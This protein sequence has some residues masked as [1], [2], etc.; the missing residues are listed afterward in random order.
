MEERI[1]ARGLFE[2]SRDRLNDLRYEYRALTQETSKMIKINDV[3]KT[4]LLLN[5]LGEPEKTIGNIK[6]L[7]ELKPRILKL[8][9]E[10]K[11]LQDKWNF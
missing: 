6:K 7:V 5:D 10:V 1:Y 9:K 8:Q 4:S 3:D 2:E 11:T